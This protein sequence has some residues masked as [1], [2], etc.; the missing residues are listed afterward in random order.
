VGCAVA[1]VS[2]ITP[3][4]NDELARIVSGFPIVLT[5][6][7]HY[8]TG[9]L[10]SLVCETVAER[11]LS[12]RVIRCGVKGTARRTHWQQSVPTK[13]AWHFSRH[14]RPDGPY[15]LAAKSQVMSPA[16]VSVILPVC[17]EAAYLRQVVDEYVSVLT[18]LPFRMN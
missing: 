12:C 10:G 6:E 1:A 16:L 2:S 18:R 3:D 7:A 14:A 8:I 5:V 9:G 13:S 4:L 11:N 17:N 15:A